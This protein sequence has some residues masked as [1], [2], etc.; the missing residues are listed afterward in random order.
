MKAKTIYDLPIIP[1]IIAE[2][3]FWSVLEADKRCSEWNTQ[4]IQ[5]LT[6]KAV[7]LLC[8]RAE[9]HYNQ[10][11]QFYKGISKA[12]DERYYLESFIEQWSEYL[13][14][15]YFNNQPLSFERCEAA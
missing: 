10:K 15:L 1:S 9:L 6:E 4:Q 8:D 12:K 3:A 11:G 7:V 14:N 13:L 5:E 2:N